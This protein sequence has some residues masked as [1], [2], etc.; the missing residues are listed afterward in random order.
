M[1][2]S[3]RAFAGAAVSAALAGVLFTS[4]PAS[5]DD[6]SLLVDVPGD[7]VGFGHGPV[8]AALE[9]DRLAPGGSGSGTVA[10]R[11]TSSYVATLSLAAV[12]V[13]SHENSCIRPETRIV[14]EGCAADGGELEDWLEVAVLHDAD[15]LW[16]GTLSDLEAAPDLGLLPAGETWNLQ[17]DVTLP[18]AAANDTMTD[19]V[20]FGLRFG[21]TSAEGTSTVEGPDVDVSAPTSHDGGSVKG[22]Q[23]ALPLTGG[24]ISLW[25]LVLDGLVLLVG[26]TLVGIG[27]VRPS[28]SR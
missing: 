27:W 22:A 11:N 21:A 1:R 25:M 2:R 13:D 9:I 12:G 15:L 8:G 17:L 7:G 16:Q 20:G 19:S 3:M 18:R 6:G 23:I 24:R 26:G 4:A 14:T 28:R 10:V 5:A